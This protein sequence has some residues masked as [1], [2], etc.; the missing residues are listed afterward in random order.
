MP[1][2]VSTCLISG[3]AAAAAWSWNEAFLSRLVFVPHF[4]KRRRPGIEKKKEKVSHTGS[5][6]FSFS[7]NS[8]FSVVFII[9]PWHPLQILCNVK[10]GIIVLLFVFFSAGRSIFLNFFQLLTKH[11]NL[12]ACIKR[13]CVTTPTQPLQR[14]GWPTDH[15]HLC[16][17]WQKT[18]T[19]QRR[20]R[21]RTTCS[22]ASVTE[23]CCWGRCGGGKTT[24]E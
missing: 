21:W 6:L 20:R 3:T 1:L 22:E 23:S 24:V 19:L 9:S 17:V 18:Q 5:S 2:H 7:V 16:T 15:L 13:S 10:A 11:V 8:F 14:N 12:S 4:K